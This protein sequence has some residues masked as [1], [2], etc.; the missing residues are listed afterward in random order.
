MYQ[1]VLK[2]ASIADGTGQPLYQGDVCIQDGRIADILP[3]CSGQGET[4]LDLSGLVAAP[5]F[6]DIHTHSDTVPLQTGC[7]PES[8]LQQGVTL[9]IT[10]NCG[11]SH[12][13]APKE[14]QEELARFYNAILP[15]SVGYASLEDESVSDYAAHV[16]Q[17]PPAI[18]YGVLIGHGTLRGAVMGFD[19]RQP[20]PEEQLRMERL[21]DQQ[22]EEG[23][24]GM[25]LGLIYPP[26]SFAQRDELVGLAKVLAAR[27]CILSVHIRNESDQV[28]QSVEE[29]LD[30]ARRSGVHLELSHLKLMGKAQWGQTQRLLDMLDQ[31]RAQGVRVTC[32]QYPYNAS[33]TGLS[34][35]APGWAHDGGVA[36]LTQRA[37]HPSPQ[38]LDAI[39]AEMERRGGASAVLVV[40]TH[41]CLP[42]V[43]G[44][45][46]EEISQLWSIPPAEATARCLALCGGSVS[47]IY[48]TMD[49]DDVCRIMRDMN[50]S[51]GSDGV[52]YDYASAAQHCFH[53]R[54]FG[55]FP[56]FLQT[57]R[58]REL[59][60]V[61]K[62]VYKM[63]G[64]PARVLGL[65]D[66][67]LL[68]PGK[69]AD[70]TVFDPQLIADR[71]TF[72]N[73]AVKPAGIH[74]VFVSGQLALDHGTPTGARAGTVLLHRT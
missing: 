12:L 26:S 40:D 7:P 16:A 34:A 22:L 11:I 72:T 44:K 52:S 21:L 4:V 45:T 55:T 57:V 66:R 43:H 31:A 25:S 29:M 51:V 59:M 42:E 63:T 30:V 48:F 8:K 68:Q 2:N 71:S 58:E 64:L 56:R 9:E 10:G 37:Q 46:L 6:I 35:L 23:A 54:N 17:H 28:F 60:P 5:G 70:L 18:H 20:T 19:M 61:E 41:G 62:A 47:C 1:Y 38:L 39:S 33:S 50:I 3:P 67:G 13:P 32:D 14:K 49:M 74:Y 65:K 24:F 69:A 27:G 73:S 15:A 53:P 36:C